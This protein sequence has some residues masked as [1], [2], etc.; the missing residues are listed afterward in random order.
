MGFIR[1]NFHC[2]NSGQHCCSGEWLGGNAMS[3]AS[4]PFF[5]SKGAWQTCLLLSKR[6]PVV[7]R[8]QT[9]VEHLWSEGFRLF[10]K[11]VGALLWLQSTFKVQT[12][13]LLAAAQ[14]QRRFGVVP[15]ETFYA[16]RLGQPVTTNS[17]RFS[18]T[19]PPATNDM[20]STCMDHRRK[21]DLFQS[22]GAKISNLRS[23]G[24][25]LFWPKSIF[26][27]SNVQWIFCWRELENN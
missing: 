7:L 9:R 11:S 12:S 4:P 2:K 25:L 23:S 13:L 10:L 5:S 15:H 22:P 14:K 20:L 21:N 1:V 26:E 3:K 17:Q 6:R 8:H 18:R 16:L 24:A 19:H 27:Y